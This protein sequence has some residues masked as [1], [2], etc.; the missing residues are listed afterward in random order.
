[1]AKHLEG[2]T[3][4]QSFLELAFRISDA[5]ITKYA[6][7]VDNL[8]EPVFEVLTSKLNWVWGKRVN[9]TGWRAVKSK[10]ENEG[11]LLKEVDGILSKRSV[12][13]ACFGGIFKGK[14]PNKATDIEIPKWI[15][16]T[17]GRVLQSA[18]CKLV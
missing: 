8:C 4:S 10:D 6:L 11:M 9:I 3:N 7:D 14:F 1:M 5:N 15:E 12:D 17:H 16:T 18:A 13:E 2:H